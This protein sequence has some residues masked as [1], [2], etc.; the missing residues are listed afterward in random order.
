MALGGSR[1]QI[2]LHSQVSFILLF[3]IFYSYH[4]SVIKK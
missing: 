1:T 4:L 2:H 3:F